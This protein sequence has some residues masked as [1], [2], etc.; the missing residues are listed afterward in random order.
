MKKGLLSVF[1]LLVGC[2]STTPKTG[3]AYHQV[4]G[5]DA[6][7][8]ASVYLEGDMIK[9]VTLDELT[10]LSKEE[11][12]GLIQSLETTTHKQIASKRENDDTYSE[13]MKMNGA[14]QTISENYDAIC[15]YVLGKSVSELEKEI[16]NKEVDVIASCTLENTKG[17][18]EAILKAC[19]EAV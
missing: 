17:Y 6:I 4:Y 12:D 18:L 10:Y 5:E 19:K 11:Y 16:E 3:L 13:V 7:C 1:L 9:G 2:S 14:T 15:K 8:V